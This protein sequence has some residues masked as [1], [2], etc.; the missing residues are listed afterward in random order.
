MSLT[1]D[2][3][4]YELIKKYPGSM[5]VGFIADCC[6]VPGYQWPEYYRPIYQEEMKLRD[7]KAALLEEIKK[8][9]QE[10]LKYT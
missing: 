5:E 10:I 9:D 4:A 2:R 7:R 3:V 8:I 1:N 6:S